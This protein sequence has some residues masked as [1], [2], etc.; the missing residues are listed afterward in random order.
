M[1]RQ[2]QDNPLPNDFEELDFEIVEEHWNEYYLPD[3]TRIKGRIFLTK[4]I[5][6]PN[7]PNNISISTSIPT[8]VVYAN[9][10]N[11]GERN[12]APRHEEFNTLPQHEIMPTSNNE[13]FNRYRIQRNGQIIRIRLTV[14][15]INR[16]TDRFDNAGLPF[17]VI[18]SGPI[19][20]ADP[21]PNI[22]QGQ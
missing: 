9:H 18:N 6:D 7:N 17:F 8:W 20:M 2:P 4:L 13:K 15:R 21:P 11:R 1:S 16:I 10:P 12:N 19:V 14:A 3:N 5:R 22:Q